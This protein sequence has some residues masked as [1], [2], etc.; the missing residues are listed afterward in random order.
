MFRGFSRIHTNRGSQNSLRCLICNQASMPGMRASR[1]SAGDFSRGIAVNGTSDCGTEFVCATSAPPRSTGVRKKFDDVRREC[2]RDCVNDGRISRTTSVGMGSR[3]RR[4]H[5][6][7]GRLF[8]A[9]PE[10]AAGRR[11]TVVDCQSTNAILAK[12]LARRHSLVWPSSSSQPRT[13]ARLLDCLSRE[14]CS[15]KSTGPGGHCMAT[16]GQRQ[17]TDRRYR[18]NVNWDNCH[19]SCPSIMYPRSLKTVPPRWNRQH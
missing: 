3:S 13:N 15:R 14:E 2:L 4:R 17:T 1:S 6:R 7:S 19:P 10:I 11:S 18:G 5:R 9:N 16:G 8:A 12:S